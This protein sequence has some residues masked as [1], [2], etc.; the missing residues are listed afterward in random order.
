MFYKLRLYKQI[1]NQILKHH[2]TKFPNLQW[3]LERHSIAAYEAVAVWDDDILASPYQINALFTEMANSRASVFTPC[4]MRS[5]Y[6][7]LKRTFNRKQ[8][9]ARRVAFIEMNAPIFSSSFLTSFIL[10]FDP[11]IKGWETLKTKNIHLYIGTS[12]CSGLL[13]SASRLIG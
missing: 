8:S 4:M 1:P 3:Y 13:R 12:R 11:V 2:D 5:N 7:Y 9:G 6:E 10:Q